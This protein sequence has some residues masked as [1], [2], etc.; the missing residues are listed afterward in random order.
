MRSVWLQVLENVTVDLDLAEL[1]D[2]EALDDVTAPLKR[3]P[4]NSTGST[5]LV[6]MREEGSMS[7]GTAAALL[8]FTVKEVDATTGEVEEDGY[9]DEYPLEDIEVLCRTVVDLRVSLLLVSRFLSCCRWCG[10]LHE[11]SGK[12]R[13]C[14]WRGLDHSLYAFSA[15]KAWGRVCRFHIRT[16]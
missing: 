1:E 3:M 5:F 7:R 14:L 13:R 8:K 2:M 11:A 6:L 9:E 16:T 15:C 4:H 10:R 12:A